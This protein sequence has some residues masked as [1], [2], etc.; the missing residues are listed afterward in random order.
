MKSIIVPAIVAA[1][2]LTAATCKDKTSHTH[3]TDVPVSEDTERYYAF[4][5]K[6][7]RDPYGQRK[8]RQMVGTRFQDVEKQVAV[9]FVPGSADYRLSRDNPYIKI[10]NMDDPSDCLQVESHYDPDAD[11]P[12]YEKGK[13]KANYHQRLQFQAVNPGGD[14]EPTQQVSFQWYWGKNF[15]D[16]GIMKRLTIKQLHTNK[17]TTYLLTDKTLTLTPEEINTRFFQPHS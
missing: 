16:Y 3:T 13:D 15:T 6:A 5:L 10:V 11:P 9:K 12:I 14:Q 4:K 8:E 17:P 2:I 7:Y 1:C